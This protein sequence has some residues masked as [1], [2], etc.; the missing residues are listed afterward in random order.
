MRGRSILLLVA[1]AF[2]LL[3]AFTVPTV[4]AQIP[5]GDQCWTVRVTQTEKGPVPAATPMIFTVKM[6]IVPQDAFQATVSGF[7]NEPGNNPFILTGTA[8][9][10]NSSIYLNLATSQAHRSEPWRDSG[11]MQ[12]VLSPTTLGGTFW[13]IRNDY[14][15]STRQFVHGYSAGTLTKKAA[16]Q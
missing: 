3:T 8:A 9:L 6:H 16:C 14:N 4:Q 13:E 5:K 7:V 1:I 2:S 15:T 10:V 11:V 12:A